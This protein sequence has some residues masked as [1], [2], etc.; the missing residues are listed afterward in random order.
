VCPE[1]LLRGVRKHEIKEQNSS[2][3]ERKKRP[4]EKKKI[5]KNSTPAGFELAPS[6]HLA[7]SSRHTLAEPPQPSKGG[8]SERC[9]TQYQLSQ[10]RALGFD[11]PVIAPRSYTRRRL[12]AVMLRNMTVCVLQLVSALGRFYISG[13]MIGA[14]VYASMSCFR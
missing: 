9:G 5:N 13:A 3:F 1:S 12:P 11:C 4:S 8:V 10:S 6:W 14:E 7:G 2:R